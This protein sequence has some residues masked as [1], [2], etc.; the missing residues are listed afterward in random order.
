MDPGS[1]LL[2]TTST[3]RLARTPACGGETA[4][5]VPKRRAKG[6]GS[7]FQRKDGRWSGSVD[8]GGAIG[9]K[10]R[11]F[12]YG[13]TKKQVE[14]RVRQLVNHVADGS[15]P[16]S[17]SPQLAAFLVQWLKAVR[18]TLRP[19]TYESYEYV[20]RLHLVPTIGRITLEKLSVDH[21]A[22]LI[23][24]KQDEGR[25]SATT[26][27]YVL[28]ILRN[29]LSKAVRWGLVGRN[30]ANLV[31]P[32]RISHKDVRVLSPEETKK[33]LDA[34]RGEP[35]EGLVFLAVSTGVRLGEALGLQWS[36]IDLDRRQ[37][38]INKALQRVSGQGLV[39][40]ET[41]THRSRRTLVLPVKTAEALR[42]H[43]VHQAQLRRA[44]GSAWAAKDFVFTSSNGQPLDQRNVLRMFRRV[45]RKAK[46]PRMRFHDLRHSCASLLFAQHIPAR[47]V[48]ETLG[49]SRI[50]V[51]MDTYTHVMPALMQDAADAM[52]RSLSSGNERE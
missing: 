33:L 38:R 5:L 50:S 20:A 3:D 40:I 39:L 31:D 2:A 37:L 28:L 26:V 34:A 43:R 19:S 13:D 12:V 10:R 24:N 30:V 44:A 6:G 29:A 46:L 17:R 9:V 36:D 11:K 18:P 22:S 25:H 42:A 41:K 1:G 45:L 7:V 27:R 4:S 8:L 23:A 15:P 49:H 16:Q 21:V 14:E 32:P 52:D 47:V 48:M 35:I 51:T